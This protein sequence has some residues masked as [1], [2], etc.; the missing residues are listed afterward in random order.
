MIR[1]LSHAVGI[2]IDLG[3][4]ELD[5]NVATRYA[6]A[7][8]ASTPPALGA[9]LPLGL[10][11]SLRGAPAPDVEFTNDTV[12]V[13]AGHTIT[14]PRPFTV[15]THY[16]LTSRIA[17]VFEKSGR[18]GPLTVVARVARLRDP[19]GSVAA[20]LEDQQIAR[21][22]PAANPAA[23]APHPVAPAARR[24]TP[25][26]TANPELHRGAGLDLGEV[27]AVEHRLAPCPQAVLRYAQAFGG[28]EPLF[29]DSA[30]ARSI[31]YAD[32]I[33]PGPLQAALLEH[34]LASHLPGW[35]LEQISLTFRVS[36]IASEAIVL[37]AMVIG[38]DAHD[39]LAPMVLDLTL[40]NA[41]GEGAAVGTATLR[42]QHNNSTT[43]TR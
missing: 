26:R 9:D 37:S 28:V 4:V 13:H 36:V 34:M 6:E 15:A 11:F 1:R 38:F 20:V 33:V 41:R 24:T 18:S 14:L 2:E 19:Q 25:G 21:W 31:G 30:F 29:V 39:P 10:V 3:E 27:I 5:G 16:H 23:P 43:P 40:E 8:G 35:R 12:S 42:H 22:R 7:I 32:V 17:A